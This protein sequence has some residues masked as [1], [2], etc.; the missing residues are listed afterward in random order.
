MIFE[1]DGF[2]NPHKSVARFWR[3]REWRTTWVL[4]FGMVQTSSVHNDKS[5]SIEWKWHGIQPPNP[6]LDYLSINGVVHMFDLPTAYELDKLQWKSR[7]HMSL[8]AAMKCANWSRIF[9]HTWIH[10]MGKTL[11]WWRRDT[12]LGSWLSSVRYITSQRNI[13]HHKYIKSQRNILH[14]GRRSS[15]E[16]KILGWTG[17]IVIETTHWA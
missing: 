15:D 1:I 13:L 5:Y 16:L 10:K 17:F 3:R 11:H 9:R 8:P 2:T 12:S 4:W 7:W 14:R 6:E